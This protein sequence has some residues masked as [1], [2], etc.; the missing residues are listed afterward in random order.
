MAITDWPASDRPRE[1]LLAQGPQAL[2]DAELLALFLRVGIRG[3]TAVDLAREL[4][5]RFGS[6]NALF[7]AD[8]PGFAAVPGMGE[9]KFAQ[10]QAVLEMA[11]RA[12]NET[13]SE[14]AAFNAP[15]A[16]R[17]FLRLHLG[18]ER[19]EVFVALWLDTANKLIACDEIARGTHNQAAVYPREVARNGLARHAAAVIFA[20]N[21]PAGTREPSAAD[22]QL[23]RRLKEALA[24]FDIRT[25]DH[26]IVAGNAPPLSFAEHGW[27]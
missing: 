4:L 21:H 15:G 11:K 26:F 12:L 10:L 13:L 16:V 14:Q 7:A 17:D 18:Q 27:L 20:H 2:S 9:A 6:L 1:K 23:T 25:L 8:L 5:Q 3:K 24:L 22:Q 19:Q